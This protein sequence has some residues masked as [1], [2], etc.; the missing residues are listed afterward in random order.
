MPS[1]SDHPGTPAHRALLRAFVDRYAGD[2]RVLAVAVFGS[3][4]RGDWDAYSDLDLDVVLADGVSVDPLAEV[5]T[6]DA[7]FAPAGERALLVIPDGDDAADVVLASL[8]GL[9]IRFHP[10][11]ATSPNIV[12]SL[13]VLGGPLDREAVAAAGLTNRAPRPDIPAWRLDRVV[14]WAM[15]VETALRRGNFWQA[16]YLMQRMRESLLVLFMLTHG[17]ERPYHTFDAA[18]PAELDRRLEATLHGPGLDA[19]RA[20]FGRLLDVIERDLGVLS[21]GRL[22]LTPPQRAVL[23]GV[24]LRLREEFPDE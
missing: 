15:N 6:L 12:D 3:L 2:P 14:R 5:A 19:A 18:A 20:A 21:A 4:G 17:G 23:T 24:R 16:A 11:A 9:S 7:A 1:A 22:A 8:R 10:L 13:L